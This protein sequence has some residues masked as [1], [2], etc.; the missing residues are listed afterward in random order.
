MEGKG[1]QALR[2]AAEITCRRLAHLALVPGGLE[3]MLYLFK[4]HPMVWG[5]TLLLLILDCIHPS[6]TADIAAAAVEAT[7]QRSLPHTYCC[8]P[9]GLAPAAPAA[10]RVTR[11][12]T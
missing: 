8:C 12:T 2:L 1:S 9:Q 10:C 3:Q 7:L 6:S 4:W 5:N 11:I